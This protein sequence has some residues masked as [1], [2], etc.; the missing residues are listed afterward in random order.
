LA[1]GF[2]WSLAVRQSSTMTPGT[3]ALLFRSFPQFSERSASQRIPAG[4]RY[5]LLSSKV[6]LIVSLLRLADER[7]Q[8]DAYKSKPRALATMKSEP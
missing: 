6:F 3:F 7:Y 2:F 1:Q 5:A 8:L 4:A